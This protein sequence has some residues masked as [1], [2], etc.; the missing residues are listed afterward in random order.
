MDVITLKT[1]RAATFTRWTDVHAKCMDNSDVGVDGARRRPVFS[2]FVSVNIRKAGEASDSYS[3]T[4]NKA[5]MHLCKRNSHHKAISLHPPKHQLDEPQPQTRITKIYS[6][7]FFSSSRHSLHNRA[8]AATASDGAGRPARKF[9][10]RR[11][12][13]ELDTVC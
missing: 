1:S 12:Q 9:G 2:P 11:I 3:D 7:F 8:P 10:V 5:R 6:F 4:R 13:D